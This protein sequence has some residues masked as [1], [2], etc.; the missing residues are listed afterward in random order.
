[1]YVCLWIVFNSIW[2]LIWEHTYSY[3]FFSYS[4]NTQ[5]SDISLSQKQNNATAWI[6]NSR[7]QT[8]IANETCLGCLCSYS[9]SFLLFFF[10]IYVDI[11]ILSGMQNERFWFA[12]SS[13]AVFPEWRVHEQCA[14]NENIYLNSHST[15]W[16]ELKNYYMIN[17]FNIYIYVKGSNCNLDTV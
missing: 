6:C 4:P 13:Y 2:M 5:F 10:I 11:R 17:I 15:Q 1:M 8:K 3:V 7:M 16:T 9:C 14:M 12:C